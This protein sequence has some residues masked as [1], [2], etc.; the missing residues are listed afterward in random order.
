VAAVALGW[1]R[2]TPSSAFDARR[3]A[4]CLAGLTPGVLAL[5]VLQQHL[6]GSPFQSGYG[7]TS[8]FFAV[9]N[10]WPNVGDYARRLVTGEGPALTLAAAALVTLAISRAPLPGS[11]ALLKLA[12]ASAILVLGLYLPFGVFPDWAY[13][14]FLMPALPLAFAALGAVSSQAL[15]RAA[16]PLRGVVL[17]ASL[18]LLVSLNV[19]QAARQSVYALRDYEAR[20]RTVGRY[21]ALSSRDTVILASQ[22]SGSAHYYS[23]LP[24]LRWDLLAVDLDTAIER[25]RALGRHPVLVVEDWEKP[26]LRQR[27]PSGPTASLDWA[28]RADTGRTTRVGVWDPADR[29]ADVVTDHLP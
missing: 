27:F 10:I 29:G 4:A 14:R 23:R 16:T 12:A 21:L 18:T 26:A 2:T 3:L 28:P 9:A 19:T 17:L 13:L 24:V 22:E 25:M 1:P 5:T 6:Y 7:D 15:D 20:Y 11:A 8:D